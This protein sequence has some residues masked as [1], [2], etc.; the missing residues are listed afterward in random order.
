[1]NASGPGEPIP[2]LIVID[3]E[4]DGIYI[5]PGR[6]KPWRGFEKAVR[7]LRDF[8]AEA[9]AAS[10]APAHFTWVYRMDPQIELGYGSASWPV[11]HYTRETAEL[12]GA[13]DDLG[14]HPHGFR[15]CETTRR[16]NTALDDQ[17]WLDE[18]LRVASDAFERSLGSRCRTFR[19]GDHWMSQA[20][21]ELLQRLGARYDL[22]L[23][24]GHPQT[25]ITRYRYG[26]GVLPDLSD[27]PAMPYR[28][29]RDDY[30]VADPSRDDGLVCIPMTTS[31]A[32]PRL[33]HRLLDFLR[34]RGTPTRRWVAC[35]SQDPFL[36][37]RII[38]DALQR[39]SG[40]LGITV[41]S[42]AFV[43]A[44]LVPRVARNLRW[45]LSHPLRSM[46]R[47]STADETTAYL[48]FQ[49]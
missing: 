23:E 3:V 33:S 17:A 16:W 9:T 15:W 47:W 12:H 14:L 39:R 36:F 38:G 2:V 44:R 45:L 46:F 11:A 27:I 28:P 5:E 26:T 43:K 24:P 20:T 35:L 40:H 48:G 42:D 19:Y 7:T 6:G 8:R 30:R 32:R 34:G 21:M 25:P 37:R 22:T 31:S 4:P 49:T 1:M 29:A 41:R 13:G 10:G 18:C